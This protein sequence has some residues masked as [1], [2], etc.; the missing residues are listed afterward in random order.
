M[1]KLSTEKAFDLLPYVVE[2]Y[3]KMN[4]DKY[5]KDTRRKLKGKNNID[6]LAV[7]IDMFK[8]V[9]KNLNKAEKEV[10]E[11]I[12]ILEEKTVEEVRVQPLSITFKSLKDLLTNKELTNFFKSAM[13]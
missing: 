1:S 10:F 4:V 2:I 6:E 5:I 3:E 8:F 9:L 11:V 13:Q 12:A 7:G